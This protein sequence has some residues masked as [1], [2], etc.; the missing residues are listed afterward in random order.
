M[1]CNATQSTFERNRANAQHST[2][3][4]TAAGKVVSRQNALKHGMYTKAA[5]QERQALRRLIREMQESLQEID[6]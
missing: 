1:R 4:K 3:P 6:E 2:G 5:L